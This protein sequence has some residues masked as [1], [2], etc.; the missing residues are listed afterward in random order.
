[1]PKPVSKTELRRL[2]FARASGCCEYCVSQA[3]YSTHSFAIEHITPKHRGGKTVL[4]NL[5]LACQGCNNHKH[6]KI[7]SRDP[8]SGHLVL[9]FHPRLHNWA[10]H[11]SW[12]DDYLEMMGLTPTGRATIVTL[13]LN[14]DEVMNL[15]RVLIFCGE[16]PPG[17]IL[18][19][20]AR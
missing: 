12:S 19:A 7:K 13:Q 4:E 2:V 14:R 17:Q 11:F 16:H 15:R 1:M 18:D 5:A 6:T 3:C 8:I 20:S 10:E 9:L